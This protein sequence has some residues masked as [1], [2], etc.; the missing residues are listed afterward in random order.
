MRTSKLVAVAAFTILTVAACGGGA[1][2]T[3]TAPTSA[4]T[5]AAGPGAT[6]AGGGSTPA[7]TSGATQGPAQ[8]PAAVAKEMCGLL[9]VDDLK[10]ATG[11]TYGAGVPD[12]F[13]NCLWRVGGATVNNG[14]GQVGAAIA[15]ATLDQIKATFAGG[16]DLTVAGHAA[17]W[18]PNEGLGAIWIDVNGRLLSISL[19]PI[20]D[21]GQTI[22]SKLAEAA[23]ARM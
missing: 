13:G 11:D 19:S 6:A 8:D 18:N 9:T 10:A 21:D 3:G 1:A 12:E 17:Y 7:P 20:P 22:A 2:G 15:P 14:K 16:V 4:A 5:Q 23:A